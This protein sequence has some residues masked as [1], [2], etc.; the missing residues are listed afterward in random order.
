MSVEMMGMVLNSEVRGTATTKM[1]LLGLANH[2]GP[3]G[4]HAF[5]SVATLARYAQCD[6]RTVRRN[7]RLLEAEGYIRTVMGSGRRLPTEYAL[8]PGVI[9]GDIVS[10]HEDATP[11]DP[12]GDIVS[13]VGGHLE[14][15]GGTPMSPEPSR[16]PSTSEPSR[17]DALVPRASNGRVRT[18]NDDLWD[19]LASYLQCS[20]TNAGEAGKW[21]KGVA[22]LL[23]SGVTPAEVSELG[24]MY[25]RTY[26][27]VDLNPMAL[28]MHVAELRRNIIHGRP[29]GLPKDETFDER[30]DRLGIGA[31][32]LVAT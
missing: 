19:S 30:M 3:Q 20:P 10:S 17:T 13:L 23:E 16:E 27:G 7:L 24:D 8:V 32:G 18:V 26:R 9:R 12:R 21:T 29:P 14:P 28:A 15:G 5:P 31:E 11:E 25:L 4:G 1:V 2:S 22:L 6:E